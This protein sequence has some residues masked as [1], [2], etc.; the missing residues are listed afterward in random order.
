VDNIT[1][2]NN[3][4]GIK[5]FENKRIRTVWDEETE[6]WY[7]SIVDIVWVLTNQST[8]R[9][10]STYWAVMKKRLKDEGANELLT[11]CKQL[12]M[13]SAD[14]KYYN[15]DSANIE[16]VLRIIQSIPS[17]KAEPFKAWLAKVGKDRIDETIDPELTIDRA[18]VTYL[19]KGYS[20]EWIN[21]RLQAIQV[22]KELTDELGNRGVKHGVE[23]AILTDEI[24]KAWTGMTTRQYKNLKGLKK[25]NL[26][27]NM[28]TLEVVLNMLAEATTAEISK[29]KKPQTFEE[30]KE[31]ARSGGE[32]AGIARCEAEKRSGKPVIT[33][34]NV[35]NFSQLFTEV[36]E[37]KVDKS[38]KVKDDKEG[39]KA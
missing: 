21:Q 8:P 16:Q 14:G 27:D 9:N 3:N 5:L 19:R 33:S 38:D 18:L 10:A 23:Y 29:E 7:F 30:N 6:E 37:Y 35:V 17:P 4:K 39:E 26:R 24:T 15:T 22:R 28:T 36:I 2:D 31:V 20:R 34:K 25:A 1:E 32:V 13:R 11:N 12:K